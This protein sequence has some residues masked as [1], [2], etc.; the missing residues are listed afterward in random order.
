M[1][2]LGGRCGKPAVTQLTCALARVAAF[3][4]HPSTHDEPQRP[5][6][7]VRRQ[8]LHRQ[9]HHRVRPGGLRRRLQQHPG[10]ATPPPAP[11]VATPFDTPV[12]GFT[13]PQSSF[14]LANY[15]QS[16]RYSLPVGTGANLLAERPRA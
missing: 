9:P 1:V 15:T 10:A 7:P 5:A 2:R 6:T 12:L 3:A 14:D 4:I 13:D 8:A 16:G 11:P